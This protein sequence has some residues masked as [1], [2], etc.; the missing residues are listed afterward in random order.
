M[1]VYNIGLS[2]HRFCLSVLIK[3]IWCMNCLWLDIDSDWRLRQA[4]WSVA[5]RAVIDRSSWRH[6]RR[7]VQGSTQWYTGIFIT[8]RH[9]P[10]RGQSSNINQG[11]GY[12]ESKKEESTEIQGNEDQDFGLRFKTY[13]I[14]KRTLRQSFSVGKLGCGLVVAEQSWSHH[15]WLCVYRRHSF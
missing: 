2:L 9:Q 8:C 14:W 3:F 11:D 10:M 4:I 7:K 6:H 13:K 1:Q 15:N 5:V 12:W